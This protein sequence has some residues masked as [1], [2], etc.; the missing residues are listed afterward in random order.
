[1]I[2]KTLNVELTFEE[3]MDVTTA[4]ATMTAS[5][6]RVIRGYGRARR[7]PADPPS[8]SIGEEVASARAFSQ[9]AYELLDTAASD[10]ED[11]LHKPAHL[12]A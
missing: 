9:L 12:R 10:I 11:A 3:D 8:P 5:D 6:G 7:N 4:T 2:T 1:M